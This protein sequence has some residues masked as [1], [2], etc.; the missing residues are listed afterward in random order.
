MQGTSRTLYAP[1][2]HTMG[3]GREIRPPASGWSRKRVY[4]LTLQHLRRFFE[5]F[6]TALGTRRST[7]TPTFISRTK[8]E[9]FRQLLVSHIS[10]FVRAGDYHVRALPFSCIFTS[11]PAVAQQAARHSASITKFHSKSPL[12]N[13]PVD[14]ELFSKWCGN[15]SPL[16][17]QHE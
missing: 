7:A 17:F 13:F 8:C 12:P 16:H 15:Q 2:R 5:P 4:L 3:I 11:F 1:P 10:D 9:V 14:S 6:Q